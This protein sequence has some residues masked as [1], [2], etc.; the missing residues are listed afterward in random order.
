[1]SKKKTNLS[2]RG[3]L[4]GAALAAGAVAINP[5]ASTRKAHAAIQG[6]PGR[7]MVV[8]NLLG[9]NDGLNMV[10][11]AHLDQ[12]RIR[13]P[14]INLVENL[15]AGEALHDLD[16]NYKLHYSLGNMKSLWDASEL[17]VVQKVSY[18]SPNQSHFTSQDIW[19]FGVRD[20]KLN[21]DGR[22]WLGRYAD[23]YCPG[24]PLGVISVGLG[25]RRDFNSDETQPLVLSSVSGFQVDVDTA[26]RDDHALRLQTVK[27]I[28]ATD[29]VPPEDP[30]LSI[31]SA[32]Q[33]SYDLVEQVAS[34]TADWV[35][36]E[37]RNPA[38]PAYGGD[39]LGRFMRTISQLLEAHGTF[40][41]KVFYTGMG[42][43]DTHSGQ[44]GATGTNRHQ[45]LMQR[46]DAAVGT[47]KADM[48]SRGMWNNCTLVV[49]SEFGRRI[50]ENGSIGTD[51]GHGNC[52]M[53]CGG[54]VKGKDQTGSGLTGDIVDAD[55]RVVSGDPISGNPRTV[56]FQFDF[57]DLYTDVLERHLGVSNVATNIF[58]DPQYTPAP[59]DFDLIKT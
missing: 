59:N 11:P 51:H 40:G 9:G 30:A 28:L 22:G 15:P 52:V 3:F 24:E 32:N 57:R 46:L 7:F 44:H 26:F 12:Y 49:I 19:S 48:V 14:A 41:T 2:R 43:F 31:F 38:L 10:V 42:G 47:F 27:D 55:I 20:P 33:Q 18:P 8:I 36:P 21:G 5:I 29:P 50:Y 23:I 4:R 34:E 16:G 6:T 56:P 53:V 37:N 54:N 25:K 13:R 39:A 1:M 17:H 58:P 35:P 45:T